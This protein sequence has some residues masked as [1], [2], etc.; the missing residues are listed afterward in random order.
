MCGPGP[1]QM[2]RIELKNSTTQ[3]TQDR[4]QERAGT[5]DPAAKPQRIRQLRA[6]STL[7]AE[8]AALGAPGRIDFTSHAGTKPL[9]TE[10][11]SMPSAGIARKMV[12]VLKSP[13]R[14]APAS[15]DKHAGSQ[16]KDA[17]FIA[18]NWQ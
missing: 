18:K 12:E 7:P 13:D 11:G 4:A 15:K 16:Q 10:S 3:S 5:T 14:K 1:K 8:V 9:T 6:V 2:L 17:I